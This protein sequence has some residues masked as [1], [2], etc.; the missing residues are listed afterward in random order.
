LQKDLTDAMHLY[1]H[2][3]SAQTY[4]SSWLKNSIVVFKEGYVKM[5]KIT[6]RIAV[7]CIKQN[8]VD[9]Q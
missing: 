4:F 1:R 2:N 5:K 8:S 9:P 3:I 6:K 7:K